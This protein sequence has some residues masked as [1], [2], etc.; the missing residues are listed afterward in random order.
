MVGVRGN[1]NVEMSE[2]GGERERERLNKGASRLCVHICFIQ[3]KLKA[4]HSDL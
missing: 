3:W 4:Q 2:E 1:R